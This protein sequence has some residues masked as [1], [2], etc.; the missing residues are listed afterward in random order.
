[1]HRPDNR[2]VVGRDDRIEDRFW[3]HAFC[4]LEHVDRDFE[5]RVLIADRLR[6]WPLGGI[7]I[8]I[9]E[10]LGALPGKARSERIIRRPPDFA[11]QAVAARPQRIYH[12]WEQQR[13]ADR[14]YFWMEILLRSL[15]PESREV[16]RDHVPGDD[17]GAGFLEP[18]DLGGEVII[19]HLIAARINQPVAGLRQ[20]RP[21]LRITQALPSASFGNNPPTTWFV[22]CPSHSARNAAI[23]SSRPQKK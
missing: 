3:L 16:R 6:P 10:L 11:G 4:A 1:M 21:A 15:R 18:R 12:R 5:Q 2:I 7:G 19:H 23:T 17:L 8:S 14:H 20:R 9:G 22:G 13:L